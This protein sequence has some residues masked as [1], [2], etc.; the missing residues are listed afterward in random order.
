[1]KIVIIGGIAAG[2]SAVAKAR[3]LLPDAQC[4]MYE[5]GEVVSFGSCGLP[6][7]IG[8][9]FNDENEMIA[10]SIAAFEKSGVTVKTGHEVLSVDPEKK[11]ITVKNLATGEIFTDNYDQLMIATGSTPIMPP[12]TNRDLKNISVVKTLSDGQ[13]LKKYAEDEKIKDVTIIGGGS[14]GLEMAHAMQHQGKNVRMIQLEERLLPDAF[15]HEISEL[16]ADTLINAGIDL[17]IKETV[18]GFNGSVNAESVITNKGEYPTDLVIVATGVRPNTAFLK[19]TGIELDKNGAVIINKRGQTNLENIYSAGDCATIP[20]FLTDEN[21][22]VPLATGANKMGRIVGEN[23][24]GNKKEYP[25][26]LVTS[27]LKILGMEAART[28]LTEQ[29][30]KEL[31][32]PFKSVF[33]KDKN[34][35]SYYPG[36]KD[37]YIKLIYH[38][39]TKVLLGGQIAGESDAVLRIDTLAAAIFAKMT[40]ED[41][42]FLDLVYAPPFSRTWEA[43]NVAGNVAK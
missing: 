41:L 3:R 15:D 39:D 36:Q 43:L 1:M 8:D 34:H 37:I 20:H 4:I 21:I 30:A 27:G 29:Q 2:T 31:N 38:A 7:F 18:V 28:G 35:T 10:R 25:G 13:K 40:T 14:I 33:I 22:Y 19:D 24:A 5:K 6:Y 16:M 12:F 26:S 42:G 23:L 11:E 17:H 32:I 9:F